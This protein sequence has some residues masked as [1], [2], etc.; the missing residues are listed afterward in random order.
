MLNH[1]A[2]KDFADYWRNHKK[3]RVISTGTCIFPAKV[4]YAFD[5]KVVEQETN[6]TIIRNGYEAGKDSIEEKGVLSSE[7]L[8]LD[9]SPDFQ[10]YKNEKSN[11]SFVIEGSSPKMHGAYKVTITPL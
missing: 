1:E 8:H 4:Q 11:H 5:G 7:I 6:V 3:F 10:E 9:F 2:I